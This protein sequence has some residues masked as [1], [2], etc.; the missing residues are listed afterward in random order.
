MCTVSRR[1]SCDMERALACRL[2]ARLAG[3]VRWFGPQ[4][5][6]PTITL[7][8]WL[9]SRGHLTIGRSPEG[10]EPLLER[11]TQAREATPFSIRCQ[12]KAEMSNAF[13]SIRRFR[14]MPRPVVS[15]EAARRLIRRPSRRLRRERPLPRWSG[16]G[17]PPPAATA[18]RPSPGRP[19]TGFPHDHL[20]A[21]LA[22]YGRGRK[23]HHGGSDS[24]E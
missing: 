18:A 24:A 6:T 1:R 16:A 2:V 19:A 20:I 3:G 5:G 11:N 21:P 10:F 12:R 9:A 8:G 13:A 7:A 14:A 22:A 23:H 17:F 15:P 4:A